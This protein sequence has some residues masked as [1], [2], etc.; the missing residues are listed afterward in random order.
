MEK[1]QDYGRIVVMTSAKRYEGMIYKE[2]LKEWAQMDGVE[3]YYAVKEP[4]EEVQA[5]TG[6][7]NDLLPDLGM[8][9]EN[10]TALVCA[11]PS[12]IKKVAK[13]LLTLGVK[14]ADILVTLE[15]HM[16]CG[17]GKCG[18]CKVGSHYMC[19]D[20]PV[21]NYEEMQQLPPEY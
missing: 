13:D 15:T 16:R 11:S 21:F 4:T 2:E 5:Y 6:F 8:N 7:I 17:A 18:H 10:T 20:G 14:P 19:V 12:R 3:V 9:W 1:P